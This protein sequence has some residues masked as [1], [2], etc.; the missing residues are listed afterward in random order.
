MK[1][2]GMLALTL[3]AVGIGFS[4]YLPPYSPNGVVIGKALPHF[5]LMEDSLTA[6]YPSD[7]LRHSLHAFSSTENATLEYGLQLG[8]YG[9]IED[10]ITGSNAIPSTLF[11][12]LPIT[13]AIFKVENEQRQWLVLALGPF[14]SN[15]ESLRYQRLLTDHYVDSSSILWPSTKKE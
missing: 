13:P 4:L 12:T 7:T 15:D 11:N 5:I 14:K 9:S 10:A 6:P 2:L 1:G 3:V 8:I